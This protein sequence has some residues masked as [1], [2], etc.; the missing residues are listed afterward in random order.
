MITPFAGGATRSGSKVGSKYPTLVA[1][2][3]EAYCPTL[4]GAVDSYLSER[5]NAV[6]EVVIDGLTPEL[7]AGERGAH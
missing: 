4:R 6:L 5:G 2:V 7:V 1:S 3:N